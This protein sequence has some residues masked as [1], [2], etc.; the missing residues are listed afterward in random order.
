MVEIIRRLKK[1]ED[2][3]EAVDKLSIED[4]EE[5]IL[6]ANDIYYNSSKPILSD[7]YYDI[8]IDFLKLKNSKSKILKEIGSKVISKNKVK[9]DYWLGSMDKI[10]P[11]NKDLETWLNKYE[12][13]YY[14]SE[15]LDGISAL[16]IYNDNKIKLFTR[17]T[18]VEGMDISFLI[19]YLNL[20]DY[21]K[22]NSYCTNNKIKG[23]KNL[24]AFRGEL[25]I[26]LETFEENWSKLFKNVRNTVAGL[27]NS[28]NINPNLAYDLDLV[29]YEVVDP[30]YC[31]TK[32]FKIINDLNFL[33][34]NNKL[35]DFRITFKYLSN[36]LVEHKHKSL[37]QIDGIIVSHEN[38]TS[39]NIKGNPEYAFAFKD[40]FEEQIAKTKIINIEWNI[41]KNGNII[42][43]IIIE[44]VTIGGVIIKRTSGFNGKYIFDN[45]LG[46]KS[47]IELI[48]SGDVIPYIK[49]IIKSST[50]PQMPDNISWSWDNTE[51]HIKINNSNNK[52][53]LIK[54][55]Y[56]FFSTLDTKGLGEKTIEKF[57]N[58]GYDTIL[59]I[60][61][62]TI[63]DLLKIDGIKEKSANNIVDSIKLTLTNINLDKFMTATNKLGNGI[64]YEK[65]KSI[66]NI[67]PNI[68]EI[69]K[70][71]NNEEFINKIKDIKGWDD[72]T[73]LVFVKNFSNFIIFYEEIKDFIILKSH[74]IDII[75][76]NLILKDKIIVLSGFRN[77]E[78]QAKIINNGGN[79]ANTISSKTNYLIVKNKDIITD[80]IIKAHNLGIKILLIEDFNLILK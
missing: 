10:K 27:V 30:F 54:N 78:L 46:P 64:G 32:Q 59:K 7:N 77:K 1:A 26:K 38:I 21:N 9:L 22:I 39:R 47:E 6:F 37:Y 15:K 80:K 3:I 68:I 8:L 75:N 28:K 31:M 58:N 33:C 42:P 79:V 71:W 69:Y 29:L 53:L 50:K 48:R 74:N 65:I 24:I 73:A 56:Y 2:Y 11:G 72:K 76:N 25:I 4:L 16:L 23:N 52:E 61:K 44:P 67:Y 55:I 63:K 5:V 17:G 13:P 70:K 19:K 57:V 41:S 36:L 60:I 18:A 45:N 43:T 40:I 62:L 20:P 66:L 34:V 12:Q 35:V 49:E 14:V 51:T